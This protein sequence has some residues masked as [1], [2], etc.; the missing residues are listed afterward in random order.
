MNSTAQL[1]ALLPALPE[2]ILAGGAML[3]L[4]FGAYRG[5]RSAPAVALG[6]I[7][8]LVAAIAVIAWLP[9]GKVVTSV[10]CGKRFRPG[11]S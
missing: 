2:L 9:G 1:P 11:A 10:L 4:M 6:A 3:L 7:M 8:L 5:E